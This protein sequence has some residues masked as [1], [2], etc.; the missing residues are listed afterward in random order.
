MNYLIRILFVLAGLLLVF[1]FTQ[2]DYSQLFNSVNTVPM[3][4]ILACLCVLVLLSILLVS[5]KIERLKKRK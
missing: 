2:I 1:N 5:K 3:I 4:A